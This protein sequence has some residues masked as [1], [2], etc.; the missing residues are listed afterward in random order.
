MRPFREEKPPPI[1][2]PRRPLRVAFDPLHV[3]GNES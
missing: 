2:G 3:E 1:G